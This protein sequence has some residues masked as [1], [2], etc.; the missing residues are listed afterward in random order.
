MLDYRESIKVCSKALDMINVKEF[1]IL[2]QEPY[3]IMNDIEDYVDKVENETTCQVITY[4]KQYPEIFGKI[5]EL[6]NY[7]TDDEFITYCKERYPE[8]EWAYEIR[9][10]YWVANVQ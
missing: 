7:M 10:R 6:F 2:G 1:L 3:D 8:V 5:P 9:E 4:M